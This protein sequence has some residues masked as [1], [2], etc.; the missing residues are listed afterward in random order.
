M[1]RLEDLTIG[2]T[3]IGVAGNQ[4]VTI[5][6]AKFYGDSVLEVTY[7][8]AQGTLGN[9]LLY[10]EANQK[11]H[12]SLNRKDAAQFLEPLIGAKPNLLRY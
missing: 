12:D 5:L 1:V 10:R 7:R 3:V 6:A 8:D 2:S 4:P 9:Q 11:I